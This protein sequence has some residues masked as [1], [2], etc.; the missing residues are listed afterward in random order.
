MSGVIIQTRGIS[1]Y[2]S[3]MHLFFTGAEDPLHFP[4]LH[5]GTSL[6]RKKMGLT[7]GA[8]FAV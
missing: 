7:S 8:L 5:A 3:F 6:M 1:G 2:S 4:G